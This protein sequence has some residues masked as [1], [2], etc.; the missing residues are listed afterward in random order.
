MARHECLPSTK[1]V[2]ALAEWIDTQKVDMMLHTDKVDLTA[3]E[4]ADFEHQ[5]SLASRAMDVLL[6]T[7]KTFE[8]FL[9]KGTPYDKGT[10]MHKPQNVTIPPTKGL[11]AL[12]A[13]RE[14]ADKQ[15]RNGYKEVQTKLYL[16][17]W[18]EKSRMVM[19]D[20]V[21]QEW[22]DYSRDMTLDEVNQYAPLLRNSE[23]K[24][25][26]DKKITTDLPFDEK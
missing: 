13:N 7:K 11:D 20:I 24:R 25:K 17:P 22:P 19:V 5:S 9:K 8:V 1:T 16:I 14:F 12:K 21:G 3:E 6:E 26:E 18:P 2:E 15:L 10:D 23:S 4:I